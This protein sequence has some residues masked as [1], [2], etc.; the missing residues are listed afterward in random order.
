[1]RQYP[2]LL[3]K[4]VYMKE[5]KFNLRYILNKKELYFS[6]VIVMLVS[7]IQILMVIQRSEYFE[8]G[9]TSEYL[10]L[11]TNSVEDLSPAIIIV[12][13]VVTALIMSDSTWLDRNRKTEIMLYP[14]LNCKKNVIVRW[15]FAFIITYLVVFVCLMINYLVLRIIFGSGN[16]FTL[17][18]SMPYNLIGIPEL[19]LDDLRMSNPALYIVVTSGHVAFI[20]GLLSSLSYSLSF[21]IKQR[22]V[23]YFQVLLIMFG[24]EIISSFFGFENLS[25]IKQLQIMSFFTMGDAA[26]LYMILTMFSLGLLIIS[27]RKEVI[28]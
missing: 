17:N 18:Q 12:I 8:L 10:A 19:F 11:L 25:I 16:I 20:L 2:F 9:Q 14:R 23:L 24:Y 15:I 3:Q 5:L 7:F 6:F 22:L 21:Y 26:V 13:P 1:M 4:E 28:L 27:L